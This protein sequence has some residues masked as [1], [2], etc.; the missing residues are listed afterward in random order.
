[1]DERMPIPDERYRNQSKLRAGICILD[2]LRALVFKYETRE[3]QRS[4]E[5][6]GD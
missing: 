6:V 4:N 5:G 2:G 3:C 1:M